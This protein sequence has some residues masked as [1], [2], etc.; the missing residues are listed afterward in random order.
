MV[1]K[2]LKNLLFGSIVSKCGESGFSEYTY[3]SGQLRDEW[4]IKRKLRIVRDTFFSDSDGVIETTFPIAASM[5]L[6]P[7]PL[8]ARTQEMNIYVVA[9]GKEEIIDKEKFVAGTRNEREGPARN[10]YPTDEQG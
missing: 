6:D 10:P 2:Y 1:T 9:P 4:S 3:I 5:S 8:N 7:I